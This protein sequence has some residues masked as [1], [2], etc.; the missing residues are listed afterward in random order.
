VPSQTNQI[1][2]L[3][4]VSSAVD[5]GF[6]AVLNDRMRRIGSAL[7]NVVTSSGS[8]GTSGSGG[9]SGSVTQVTL[10]VP[11]TLGVESDAAPSLTLP[12]SFAPSR[13]VLLLKTAPIGAPVVVQLFAGGAV[14]GPALTASGLSVT[15]AVSGY[16]AIA[17]NALLRLD[18]TSCGTTFPGADLTFELR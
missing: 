13:M 18:I 3:E 1:G 4:V 6:L 8:S 11:G 9:S 14:W 7:A 5:A 17:A 10:T 15:A 12:V 16:P 2:N